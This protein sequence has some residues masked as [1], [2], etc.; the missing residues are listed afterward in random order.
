MSILVSRVVT[1][2]TLRRA[3][4]S[5]GATFRPF[6]SSPVLQ[7]IAA[8]QD[9]EDALADPKATILDVRGVDEILESGYLKTGHKLV[10][11]QCTVDACPL[12]SLA[13]EDLIPDKSAP[14]V[15]YCV[16]G[17]R[18]AKA[19]EVLEAKGYKNVV[20]AGGFGFWGKE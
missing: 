12:L 17:K 16:A 13:A 9:V 8:P 18:A 6:F 11:A 4:L 19:K 7:N 5:K 2:A 14:V 3:L 20:N 10:H 15:V 1:S